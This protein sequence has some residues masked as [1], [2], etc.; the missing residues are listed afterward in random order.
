VKWSKRRAKCAADDSAQLPIGACTLLP[1]VHAASDAFAEREQIAVVTAAQR[2]CGNADRGRAIA[3]WWKG[4]EDPHARRHGRRAAGSELLECRG[5]AAVVATAA[6]DSSGVRIGNQSRL[7]EN[8]T[9]A[10]RTLSLVAGGE[11]LPSP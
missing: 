3:P 5:S 1:D 10:A 6:Y 8:R 9:S 11:A 7:E 2:S 4:L